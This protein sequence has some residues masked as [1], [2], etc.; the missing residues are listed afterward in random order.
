MRK[1]PIAWVGSLALG[2]VLMYLLDPASGRRRR[3][4]LRDRSMRFVHDAADAAAGLAS[5]LRNRAS[6]VRARL[7]RGADSS[8]DDTVLEARVR[9]S[10]G[11]VASNPGALQVTSVSG[12]VTLTG[13][14]LANEHEALYRTV[15]RVPGVARW[16]SIV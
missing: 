3:S 12:I 8:A 2:V 15:S 6:G 11:R 16:S 9:A 14:V 4:R 13:P 1:R 10:L 7:Q 5:D